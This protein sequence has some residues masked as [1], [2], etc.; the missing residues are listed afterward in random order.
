MSLVDETKNEITVHYL[1]VEQH[2]KFSTPDTKTDLSERGC[3][4][5]LS[6]GLNTAKTGE[7]KSFASLAEQQ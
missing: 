3:N 7:N 2:L 1:A 5:H 6:K 4:W